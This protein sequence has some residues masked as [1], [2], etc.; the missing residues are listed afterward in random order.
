MTDYKALEAKAYEITKDLRYG[1]DE[2]EQKLM[3]YSYL[4]F[5]ADKRFLD[6]NEALTIAEDAKKVEFALICEAQVGK[7][8]AE[9]E[10]QSLMSSEWQTVLDSHKELRKERNIAML[11]R[12]KYR[13]NLD[14]IRSLMA[15]RRKEM[16]T[17]GG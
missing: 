16:E 4:C 14:C 9:K 13:R 2:L 6:A 11:H 1:P 12:D 15:N 7:S 3:E 8:L 10:R 17:L 5:E